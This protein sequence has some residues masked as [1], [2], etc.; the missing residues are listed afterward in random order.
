[1]NVGCF[2]GLICSLSALVGNYWFR[3]EA[4]LAKGDG[5][6]DAKLAAPVESRRRK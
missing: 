5:T 3:Y 2:A 1:M 4:D 6:L